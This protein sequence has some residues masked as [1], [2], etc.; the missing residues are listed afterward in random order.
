VFK[1]ADIYNE[2]GSLVGSTARHI[3]EGLMGPLANMERE[4]AGMAV[5]TPSVS[6]AQQRERE[7]A[8][9]ER[10]R[11]AERNGAAGGTG[12]GR[13]TP[14]KGA[15]SPQVLRSASV[16]GAYT[17]MS[18]Q[19]KRRYRKLGLY[20]KD[21]VSGEYLLASSQRAQL[22]REMRGETGSGHAM[23]LTPHV[24]TPHGKLGIPT[25]HTSHATRIAKAQDRVEA[26][27]KIL[28]AV[29][30]LSK[31]AEGEAAAFREVRSHL[32]RLAAEETHTR[33][34]RHRAMQV[35]RQMRF[36]AGVPE[37]V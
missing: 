32:I 11:E 6:Q 35:V 19:G 30:T 5:Q 1:N 36:D 7:A 12:S 31:C 17:P 15:A 28:A 4:A 3:K 23:H 18:A 13:A 20:K 29:D 26:D 33:E 21:P 37:W 10:R 34:T 24:H 22:L 9:A 25:S 8:S 16:A 2:P 27:P 14:S